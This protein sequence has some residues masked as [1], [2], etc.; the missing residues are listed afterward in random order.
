MMYAPE[1]L[2]TNAMT[3]NVLKATGCDQCATRTCHS[4]RRAVINP[5]ASSHAIDAAGSWGRIYCSQ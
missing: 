2:N 5:A 4:I 1:T 3:L